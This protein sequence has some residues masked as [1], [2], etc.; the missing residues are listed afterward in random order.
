MSTAG[1]QAKTVVCHLPDV[2]SRSSEPPTGK[3]APPDRFRI[4]AGPFFEHQAVATLREVDDRS[5]CT[6]P[7]CATSS[8]PHLVA[9]PWIEAQDTATAALG[10]A[11]AP[12]A[13]RNPSPAAS[14]QTDIR[15]ASILCRIWTCSCASSTAAFLGVDRCASVRAPASR[16]G[17]T[18]LPTHHRSLRAPVPP[19]GTHGASDSPHIV[20]GHGRSRRRRPRTTGLPDPSH[21]EWQ[22]SFLTSIWTNKK[23]AVRA[24]RP[25]DLERNL[26]GTH[27][28][29]GSR[30][31]RH[32]ECVLDHRRLL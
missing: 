28:T 5:L 21:R 7:A 19:G 25:E 4:Q 8:L 32:E 18:P 26:P 17:T 23:A 1:S 27:R 22:Q 14:V 6:S 16:R 30:E 15:T 9:S 13:V 24:P 31:G 12:F 20:P 29:I 3:V 11:P 2:V 10:Y